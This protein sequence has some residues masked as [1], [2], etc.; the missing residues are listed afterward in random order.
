MPQKTSGYTISLLDL[1]FEKKNFNL[2]PIGTASRR[3]AVVSLPIPR[4]V[5]MIDS[6]DETVLMMGCD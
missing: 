4:G 6:F 5:V 1:S 3:F 2:F